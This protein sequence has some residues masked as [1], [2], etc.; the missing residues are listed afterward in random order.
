MHT[1]SFALVFGVFGYF[2]QQ[3]GMSPLPFEIAFILV[4][5][6]KCKAQQAFSAAGGDPWSRF[7]SPVAV[8]FMALTV[9]VATQSLRRCLE[10]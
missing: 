3:V 7:I 6:L 10:K 4:G 8:L 5:N 2:V 1:I 9:L